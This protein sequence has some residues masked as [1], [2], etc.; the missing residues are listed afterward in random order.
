MPSRTAPLRVLAALAVTGLALTGCGSNSNS[1]A[2]GTGP[3]SSA[4]AATVDMAVPP[5][6]HRV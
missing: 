5:R 3:A 2:S 4:S 6:G 1:A